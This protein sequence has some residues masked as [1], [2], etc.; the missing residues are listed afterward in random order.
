MPRI[1]AID[2]GL[3]R[4]GI[5]VTDALQIIATP[6]ETIAT[7]KIL[8]FLKEYIF[9][10]TIECFVIGEPKK[11]DNTEADILQA[12]QNFAD[13]LQILF[14]DILIEWQDERFT[15]SIARKSLLASGYKKSQRRDKTLIDKLSAN[16][17]LTDFMIRTGKWQR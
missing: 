11:L 17:I 10:E 6:L 12:I 8:E 14:P 15:S 13:K 9:T 16:I 1:L 2:Y 3:K 5:A 7:P 4:V